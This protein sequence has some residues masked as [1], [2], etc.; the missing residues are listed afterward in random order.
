MKNKKILKIIKRIVDVLLFI[1]VISFVLSVCLQRFSNNKISFFNY[2]MFSVASGSME[3][4][5]NI[6]D[7]LFLKTKDP[8]Q[9]K[10]GDDVTYQGTSG[11]FAGKVIT[12][13]VQEINKGQ[14]GKYYF[15]T[16]GIANVIEDPIVS[17]DQIFGVVVYKSIVLSFVYSIIG[18]TLGLFICVVLPLMYIIGSEIVSAL[19]EKEEKRRSK[20]NS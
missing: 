9:I 2:R 13:Q 18:T 17:E 19:L 10:I 1:F 14:D 11:D 7:V 15:V 16:R 20:L 12:H 6:G 3:P 8:S 5:Y 4:K